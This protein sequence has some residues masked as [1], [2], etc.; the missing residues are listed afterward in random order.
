MA[1]GT[2][3]ILIITG[4]QVNISFVGELTSGNAY[5]MIIAADRGLLAADML[6]ILPDYIVGDFDSVPAGLLDKYNRMSAPVKTFPSEK[7]KTDTQLALELALM[8]DPS[9]I[10]IVG[11]TGSRLDHVLANLHLLILPL[12]LGIKAC[13]LDGNN[14]LYLSDKSFSIDKVNQYGDYVSLLPFTPEVT[15]LTL[16]GFKYPLNLITLTAGSSLGISN[17]IVQDMA[18]VEFKSGI[19]ITAE[20]RD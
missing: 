12:Q 4:G 10:D 2:N 19:L 11:A 20:T 18:Y 16:R 9:A 13:I 3:R 14:K 17:E 8:Y 5:S 7:D 6:G 15:G 1:D